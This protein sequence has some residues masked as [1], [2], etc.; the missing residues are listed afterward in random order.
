MNHQQRLAAK[1]AEKKAALR[2]S[3]PFAIL[4]RADYKTRVSSA[5]AMGQSIVH[6]GEGPAEHRA[7]RQKF[8]SASKEAAGL[9]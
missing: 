1:R 7:T 8:V 3:S 5:R 9:R 6:E 2:E 4:A